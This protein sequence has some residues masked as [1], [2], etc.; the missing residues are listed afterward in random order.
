MRT[1]AEYELQSRL[2][3]VMQVGLSMRNG[4]LS[5]IDI[6][7]LLLLLPRV[8]GLF[9]EDDSDSSVAPELHLMS[10]GT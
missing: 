5:H 2:Y 9:P 6:C 10:L 7:L 8:L 3:F 1:C 4:W